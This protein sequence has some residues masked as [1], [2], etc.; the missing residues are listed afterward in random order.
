[1]RH[2]DENKNQ[3]IFDSTIQLIN[4]VGFADLSM[5]KIAKRANLSPATIYTYYEN[6]EDLLIKLYLDVKEKLSRSMLRNI[7]EDLE[8][9]EICYIFMKNSLEFMIENKDW[10]LFLE[11]FSASPFMNKLCM[12]DTAP[13]FQNLYHHIERGISNGSLKHVRAEL[14]ISYCYFPIVQLAKEYYEGMN[15]TI[16]KEFELIFLLSWDAISQ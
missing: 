12:A 1:M 9:K 3:A 7:H 16:E 11:Q 5:S 14:V 4:D 6:K 8:I 13:M 15:T 2:K 10:F